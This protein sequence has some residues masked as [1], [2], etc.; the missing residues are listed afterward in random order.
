MVLSSPALRSLRQTL[1]T[2]VVFIREWVRSPRSMGMV[3]PSSTSLARAMASGVPCDKGGLV[4]LGAGT[5]TVTV[6]LLR[7]IAP[8]RLIV[9]EQAPRMVQLLRR[10]F[11][12]VRIVQGDASNLSA[13]LPKDE[14]VDC[15]VSS[16]PLISLKEHTRTALIKEMYT[17]LD[18]GGML[19]QYTYSWRDSNRFLKNTFRFMDSRKVWNN[20]PPARVFRFV[21]QYT[22]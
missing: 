18:D 9:V 5:G 13:Y 12:M 10:R 20:V 6:E 16:L 17:S 8:H 1:S 19:I 4:E 15:I 22:Q 2:S 14:R 11:P 7:K 21:R 3:C